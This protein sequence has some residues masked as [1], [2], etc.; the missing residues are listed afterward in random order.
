MKVRMI[1]SCV[2]LSLTSVITCNAQA[3]H[4]IIKNRIDQ[5][6]AENVAVDFINNYVRYSNSQEVKP[7]LVQWINEQPYITEKFKMI[8]DTL[9]SQAEKDDSEMGLGFDPI[10]N[11]QDYP[12]KGFELAEVRN[13]NDV[14]LVRGID[15]SDFTLNIKLKKIQED[16]WYVDG[17][18]I[19]NMIST[20][21]Q[22]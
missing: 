9:I 19:V 10:F 8:L 14:V 3:Q 15:W 1:L 20:I 16:L 11:A 18:G 12:D 17:V 6:V 5:S 7:T 13:E 2:L 4:A 21:E 22:K